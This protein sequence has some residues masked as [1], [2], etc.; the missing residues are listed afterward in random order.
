M[1]FLII[2]FYNCI[3][4]INNDFI[5]DDNIYDEYKNRSVA[6]HFSYYKDIFIGKGFNILGHDVYFLYGELKKT[7]KHDNMTYICN[8]DINKDFLSTMDAILFCKHNKGIID[9]IIDKNESIK[10]LIIEK[11]LKSKEE[12][13]KPYLLC[14]TCVLPVID[15]LKKTLKKGNGE[16]FDYFFLQTSDVSLDNSI[17]KSIIGIKNRYEYKNKVSDYLRIST[18]NKHNKNNRVHYSDMFVPKTMNFSKKCPFKKTAKYTICYIGRLRQNYGMTIPFL[19]L[20]MSRLGKDYQLII[21]PGSF[22]LPHQDPIIKHNPKK[23]HHFQA[24]NNYI[25]S[26]KVVFKEKYKDAQVYPEDY[27]NNIELDYNIDIFDPVEWG[28]Q[29][30]YIYHCDVAINFSPNRQLNY[31]CEIANTKIFDYIVCGTAI[32]TEK[33]CQNNYMVEKYN[34]GIV[35]ESVGSL[36]QY[37]DSIKYLVKNPI[38]KINVSKKFI[39]NE[40]Y[41]CRSKYIVNI[42]KKI[43]N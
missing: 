11:S 3:S 42:L 15:F 9:E 31:E 38:D 7:V 16:V 21:L 10:N 37:I 27:I 29:Y 26:K 33:G 28:H 41:E 30:D 20:L 40:N 36:Q 35:L 22:N 6:N 23:I 18:F 43:E 14:K 8:N 17:V 12:L 5:K 2:G 24:L 4:H 25:N 13:Y 32:V 1:K 39:E 34:C 19:M